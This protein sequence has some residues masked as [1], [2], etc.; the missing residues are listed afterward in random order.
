MNASRLQLHNLEEESKKQ[1]V[2]AK[3]HDLHKLSLQLHALKSPQTSPRRD[4]QESKSP[5]PFRTYI[6]H[7][8]PRI[9]LN[10]PTKEKSPVMVSTFEEI[11]NASLSR[12]VEHYE[13]VE[14]VRKVIMEM[15]TGTSTDVESDLIPSSFESSSPSSSPHLLNRSS[16]SPTF[17][18]TMTSTIISTNTMKS[19]ISSTNQL[20]SSPRK[21]KHVN[22][23]QDILNNYEIVEDLK[24]ILP[25]FSGSIAEN[26]LHHHNNNNPNPPPPL[27]HQ[28]HNNNN[29]SKLII[30]KSPGR[31]SPT[32]IAPSSTITTATATTSIMQKSLP[33]ISL[34]TA[35][36]S[37][38]PTNSSLSSSYNAFPLQSISNNFPKD[39]SDQKSSPYF[40]NRPLI[41]SAASPNYCPPS[42]AIIEQYHKSIG[43]SELLNS[44]S[45]F[46]P[47]D[48]ASHF[49]Q[50]SRQIISTPEGNDHSLNV[51]VDIPVPRP[52]RQSF[53]E[54]ML[55]EPKT[56][57]ELLYEQEVNKNKTGS[58]L[59]SNPFESLGLPVT[60]VYKSTQSSTS[61]ATTTKNSPSQLKPQP[62]NTQTPSKGTYFAYNRRPVQ[63][64]SQTSRMESTG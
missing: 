61:V 3:L 21:T 46:H 62:P 37:F 7:E 27:H 56:E 55:L 42:N 34:A 36:S 33:N 52:P 12:E 28:Y 8:S 22:S 26:H 41:Y 47:T 18:T 30:P 63:I 48:S 49:T 40:L 51:T 9:P 17:S 4:Q 57:E 11:K 14:R 13:K 53:D 23:S 60:N 15:K 16:L 43:R 35:H 20:K 29:S 1:N 54:Y 44:T 45:I 10:R 6:N 32:T 64:V 59:K 39:L 50:S 5:I 24:A 58:I 25:L 19:K 38:A 31:V 2:T